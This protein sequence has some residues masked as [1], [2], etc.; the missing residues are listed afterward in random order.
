[1]SKLYKFIIEK[2][3]TSFEEKKGLFQVS[4]TNIKPKECL[5]F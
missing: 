1:M 3:M 2:K 5:N 4:F